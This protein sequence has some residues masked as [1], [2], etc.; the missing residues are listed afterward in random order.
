MPEMPVMGP[1]PTPKLK[2]VNNDHSRKHAS[3]K[4]G[5]SSRKRSR[6]EEE[7]TSKASSSRPAAPKAPR[8]PK[9]KTGAKDPLSLGWKF[10][11]GVWV[12]LLSTLKPGSKNAYRA[13]VAAGF[14]GEVGMIENGRIRVNFRENFADKI[15]GASKFILLTK[16]ESLAHL[17]EVEP[18]VA[19]AGTQKTQK[20]RELYGSRSAANE[21]LR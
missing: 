21:E 19:L 9:A 7:D 3:E 14:V 6:G 13:G 10:A 4:N 8:V 1:P 16:A 12:K 18:P 15:L 20:T 17:A 11:T 2:S 5:Q